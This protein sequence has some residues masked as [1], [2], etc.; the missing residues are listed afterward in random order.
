LDFSHLDDMCELQDVDGRNAGEAD[1]TKHAHPNYCGL[2]YGA[3]L[4]LM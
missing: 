4:L 3:H 1:D 2:L